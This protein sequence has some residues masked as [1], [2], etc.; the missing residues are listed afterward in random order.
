MNYSETFS[1]ENIETVYILSSQLHVFYLNCRDYIKLS[2]YLTL[3]QVA[4]GHS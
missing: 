4:Y 1:Y 2:K 3:E